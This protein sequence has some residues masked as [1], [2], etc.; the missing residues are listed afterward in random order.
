[1]IEAFALRFSRVK[2]R[3]RAS[4]EPFQPSWSQA[5]WWALIANLASAAFGASCFA[6][7]FVIP[8][9]ILALILHLVLS[10]VVELIAYS[11]LFSLISKRLVAAVVIGNIAVYFV[12][13][14]AYAID[15]LPKLHI[16]PS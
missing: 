6:H 3:R 9:E 14:L 1:M 16:E 10:C 7:L 13:A 12:V 15:W 5:L 4:E 11:V 8:H 2:L